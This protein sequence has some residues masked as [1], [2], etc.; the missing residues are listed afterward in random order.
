MKTN[1]QLKSIARKTMY[2]E[3]AKVP[4]Y[5][6]SSINS[7]LLFLQL[8]TWMFFPVS[9]WVCIVLLTGDIYHQKKNDLGNLKTWGFI[10]KIAAIILF[11]ACMMLL[12]FDPFRKAR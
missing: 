11:A 5:R 4:W 10:N 8:F 1:M 6:R 12:L 2:Q 7:A 3:Y 9:L